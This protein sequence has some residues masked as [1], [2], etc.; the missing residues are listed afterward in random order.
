MIGPKHLFA[1]TILMCLGIQRAPSSAPLPRDYP[2]ISNVVEFHESFYSGSAPRGEP[3][4]VSLS[5]LGIKTIISVDGAKPD[6]VR[7][8]NHAML[9][10]HFPIGYDGVA[11]DRKAQ[12]VRAVRDLP[13]PIYLHCHHGKHRSAC[14]AGVVAVSL[15]W[16]TNEQ[17]AARMLVAGTSPGY[18]GLWTCTASA[19]P[20]SAH[21]IDA[22]SDEFP[23]ISKPDSFVDAMIEMDAIFDRLK[24]AQK[25]GWV[26]PPDHPDLAPLADAGAIADQL[27]LIAGPSASIR[28]NEVARAELREWIARSSATASELEELLRRNEYDKAS[29]V[30]ARLGAS[31]TECHSKHRD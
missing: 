23:K 5:T 2:G 9:Y 18:K 28:M 3:G 25:N 15:G 31:C 4:F 12:L 27:R 20:M 13:K 7:A 8:D 6:L 19:Q 14:V 30:F 22:A 11:D 21:D 1:L 26:A 10:V 24:L 16:M 17:A 29:R